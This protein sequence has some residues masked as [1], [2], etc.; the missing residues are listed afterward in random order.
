MVYVNWEDF[1]YRPKE[2]KLVLGLI[3]DKA[4]KKVI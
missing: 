1:E 3:Q 4:H 2:S